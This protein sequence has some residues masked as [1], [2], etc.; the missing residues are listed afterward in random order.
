MGNVVTFSA[1]VVTVR[2]SVTIIDD[3]EIEEDETFSAVLSTSQPNVVISNTT[4]TVN[5]V[6]FDSELSFT[7]FWTYI[8]MC[9]SIIIA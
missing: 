6:D 4:A 1:G 8:I 9:T 5:I 7:L 3:R 2:V